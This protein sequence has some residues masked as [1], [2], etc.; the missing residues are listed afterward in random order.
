[1]AP[2][3]TPDKDT[4]VGMFDK[5]VDVKVG[6]GDKQRSFMLHQGL[7]GYS[8]GSFDAALSDFFSSA[9][10]G[11]IEAIVHL[12]EEDIKTFE[13]FVLWLYTR[14]YQPMPKLHAKQPLGA[15]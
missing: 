8:S 9:R 5:I 15:R 12:P 11:A 10:Q 1:M 13:R 14:K 6:T 2:P 4:T 7:I 3:S